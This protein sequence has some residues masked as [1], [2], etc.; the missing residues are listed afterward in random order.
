MDDL[1]HVTVRHAGPG[2]CEVSVAG[3]LDVAT[4]PDLRSALGRAMAGC[5]RVTIDL[6][7]LQFCDCCGMSA[8]LAAARTARAEGSEIHLRAVPHA[9]SRLLRLFHTGSA[10]TIEPPDGHGPSGQAIGA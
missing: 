6:A 7:D 9:L 8:L 2:V 3:E 5:R 4:A 10:F 1:F